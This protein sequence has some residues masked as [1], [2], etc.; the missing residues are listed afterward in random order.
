MCAIDPSGPPLPVLRPERPLI[1]VCVQ[2]LD[3][4][5]HAR[6]VVDPQRSCAALRVVVQLK[7]LWLV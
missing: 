3:T 4:R 6:S 2:L 7:S 5:R 1:D